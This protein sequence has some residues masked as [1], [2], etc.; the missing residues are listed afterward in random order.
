[1]SQGPLCPNLTKKVQKEVSQIAH[2]NLSLV[3]LL[4]GLSVNLN[5]LKIRKGYIQWL[6]INGRNVNS[7]RSANCSMRK[8]V[9]GAADLGPIVNNMEKISKQAD[10]IKMATHCFQYLFVSFNGVRWPVAYFRSDNVNGHSIYL[11]FW[12]LVDQLSSFGFTTHGVIIDGFS[13]NR[14]FTRLILDPLTACI[15]NYTTVNPFNVSRTVAILQDCKHVFKKIR[16][17]L[18]SSNPN[19]KRE[20][21]LNGQNIYWCFFQHCYFFNIKRNFRF[22]HKLTREHFFLNSQ[23][24]MRNHLAT[25][26]LGPQ[27]LSV[28]HK[29]KQFLGSDGEKLNA[30]LLLLEHTAFLVMFFNNCHNIVASASDIRIQGL[31]DTLTFFHTWEQQ[32]SMPKDKHKHLITKET[33]EDIDSCIYGFVSLLKSAN[34]L[35]LTILPGY[36]NSDLIKNWFC[37]HRGLRNGF[38]MNPTLSQIG[39]ATNTNIITGSVVSSKGNAGGLSYLM[40]GVLSPTKKFKLE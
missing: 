19:G 14:Q 24:K 10:K 33:R 6:H 11:T 20:L 39:S 16:N 40:K 28:M 3:I 17:S 8:S 31:L 32:F 34:S 9:V 1:M 18:L 27:M 2:R 21:I 36:V 38:D 12:P 26:V 7:T 22:F 4:G 15:T 13:N 35:N 25:D 5:H 29:Y 30:T 23:A 37:Q